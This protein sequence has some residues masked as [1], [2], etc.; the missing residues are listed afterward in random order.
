[1]SGPINKIS[2]RWSCVLHGMVL[3]CAIIIPLLPAFQKQPVEI[4]EFTVVLDENL[5][6]PAPQ[7]D[8]QPTKQPPKID[9]PDVVE[10][11]PLKKLPDPVKD[12]VVMEKKKEKE[13]E[14][15]KIKDP[16]KPKEEKPKE[17]KKGERVTKPLEKPKVDFTKLKRVTDKQL[18]SKEIANALASGA[19]VGTRNQLPANEI[20]MCVSLVRNALYEAW[21]QPGE[22]EAGSRPA[23]L[24]IRLDAAGRISIYR[25]TQSSGSAQFDSTVLKAAANCGAIRGLTVA[26]L[27]QHD[28]MTI[29]FKLE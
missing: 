25:I 27:K 29:E 19:K 5:I 23:K 26:F 13:K 8:K 6:P 4:V 22:S 20:S 3:L 1:M 10:P 11:V 28:E 14:K 12:A 15:E 16:P 9:E 17:F 18:S 21:D 2:L 7:P 24:Y